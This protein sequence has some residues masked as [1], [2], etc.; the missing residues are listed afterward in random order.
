MIKP[1]K[2]LW[3]ENCMT[4]GLVKNPYTKKFELSGSEASTKW[5]DFMR[6][7]K[8]A[9]QSKGNLQRKESKSK[10]LI[11]DQQSTQKK[12]VLENDQEIITFYHNKIK[13]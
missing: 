4:C 2:K 10:P 6:P 7:T 5:N 11:L 12:T 13:K 9:Y 3:R 1:H 8:G